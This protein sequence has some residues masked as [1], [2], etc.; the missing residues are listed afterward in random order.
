MSRYVKS[1]SDTAKLTKS[2]NELKDRFSYHQK[3]V[4]KNN[5]E[6]Q[7]INNEFDEMRQKEI[8]ELEEKMK[9]LENQS[10]WVQE[11]EPAVKV[12]DE[13]LLKKLNIL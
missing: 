3:V 11:S 13:Y 4:E 12:T 5:K 8:Q 10:R 9:K 6:L 2:L 7:K 1:V